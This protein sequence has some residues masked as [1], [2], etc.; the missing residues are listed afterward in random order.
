MNPHYPRLSPGCLSSSGSHCFN[1]KKYLI[2]IMQTNVII[3]NISNIDQ[4]TFEDE[5]L[6]HTDN[7]VQSI[8]RKVGP[9][10]P[11]QLK[12]RKQ[13][14]I[15]FL[16]SFQ[17]CL[18]WIVAVLFLYFLL[19]VQFFLLWY[20]CYLFQC[21]KVMLMPQSNNNNWLNA[22][23]TTFLTTQWRPGTR[24]DVQIR[25]HLVPVYAWPPS[26][27]GIEPYHCQCQ[28]EPHHPVVWVQWG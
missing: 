2:N 24:W 1:L 8:L 23:L 22:I 11:Y 26:A 14:K 27:P 7:T 4:Q 18:Y 3:I 25:C 5:I 19:F 10:L 6:G 21:V 20:I 16:Y 28:T 17:F 9:Q 15:K 13:T 12:A